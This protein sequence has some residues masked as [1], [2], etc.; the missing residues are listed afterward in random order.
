MENSRTEKY[1]FRMKKSLN[2]LRKECK[3]K[4]KSQ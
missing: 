3:L 1:R 2:R 4:E